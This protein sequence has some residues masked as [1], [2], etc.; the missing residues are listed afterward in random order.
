MSSKRRSVSREIAC[1]VGS[2][3]A[4][5]CS[6]TCARAPESVL[7]IRSSRMAGQYWYRPRSG[8]A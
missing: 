5:S 8:R 4:L 7:A 3:D 1:T 6:R 2:L